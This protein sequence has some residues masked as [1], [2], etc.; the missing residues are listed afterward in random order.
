MAVVTLVDSGLPN[1]CYS[2]CMILFMKR[3]LYNYLVNINLGGG[4]PQNRDPASPIHIDTGEN[5][6]ID[7]KYTGK[8]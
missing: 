1:I 3:M 2:W 6:V 8:F 5:F 4:S 7:Y